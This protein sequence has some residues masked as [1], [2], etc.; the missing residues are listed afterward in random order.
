[1]LLSNAHKKNGADWIQGTSAGRE[2]LAAASFY[3]ID[4]KLQP[5]PVQKK[6][7]ANGFLQILSG[8][9]PRFLISLASAIIPL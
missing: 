2:A 9:F 8:R 6:S 3:K 4:K 7:A 5:S 1:M